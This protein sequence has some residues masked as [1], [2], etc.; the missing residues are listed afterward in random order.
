MILRLRSGLITS[1]V[2]AGFIILLSP[3]Q[4]LLAHEESQGQSN[5]QV[6]KLNEIRAKISE[7]E[8]LLGET[9]QK[10]LTLQNEIAYQDN[11]IK[12]TT[13]KIEET[14]AEIVSLTGQIDRLEVVLAD[15]STVFAQRA[16]ETYKLKRLGDSLVLLISSSNVSEFISRFHYLKKL[17]E[18]DRTLLLQVQSTQTNYEDKRTEVEA[19]HA[20]LEQQKDAL[21]RQ[22]VQK[23]QLLEVTKNDEAEYQKLL[24]RL[25]ADAASIARALSSAGAR[26]GDVK[27]GDVIAVVGNTGCSTGPHLHFEVWENAKVENNIFVGGNRVNPHSRL[28]NGQFQHPLSGSSITADYGQTYVG[29]VHTGIDFAFPWSQGP[30]AGTPILAAE[31]GTAYV[32][33]D[34]QACPYSWASTNTPGKGVVI[35]HKNGLVTLYWHIP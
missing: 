34:S 31:A 32:F 14:E 3:A 15:L 23:Q 4:G 25:R 8:K 17:Q 18:H 10:K 6:N 21:A 12:L 19:L 20:K 27:K 1:F 26:V 7:T 33:Q 35:D 11:Q 22:K 13:L 29:G 16:V 2:L 30:T 9:K 5:D 28:D 24:E